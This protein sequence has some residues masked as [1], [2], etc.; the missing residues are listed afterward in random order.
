MATDLTFTQ[1]DQGHYEASCTSSGDRIAVKINRAASGTLLVYGTIEDLDP[2][3]LY[4]FGP[5]SDQDL[6]F[7]IDAPSDVKLTLVSYTEVT[8][9][10]IT[11][12]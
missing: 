3:I 11:G 1:N 7:E 10:K 5:G 8:A 2:S 12:V 9:A 4:D 6:M